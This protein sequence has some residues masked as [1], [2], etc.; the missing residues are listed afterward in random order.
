MRAGNGDCANAEVAVKRRAARSR[1]GR[2]IECKLGAG[3]GFKKL[4]A[5]TFAVGLDTT[6]NEEPPQ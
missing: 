2:F 4:D 6:K 3:E 1:A 5:S